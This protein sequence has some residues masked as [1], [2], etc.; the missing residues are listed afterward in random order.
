MNNMK[1]KDFRK[2]FRFLCVLAILL[3][4]AGMVLS[5]LERGGLELMMF[6]GYLLALSSWF[7]TDYRIEKLIEEGKVR[8]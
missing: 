1:A 8:A 2:Q 4:F 6:A 7:Y 3:M 5:F